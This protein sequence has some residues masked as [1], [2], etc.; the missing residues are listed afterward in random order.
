MNLCTAIPKLS[1]LE[2]RL[3][4]RACLLCMMAITNHELGQINE[5]WRIYL[6]LPE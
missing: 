2:A 5:L 4:T 6:K 3:H 1:R